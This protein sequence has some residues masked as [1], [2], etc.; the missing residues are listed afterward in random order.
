MTIEMLKKSKRYLEKLVKLRAEI[1]EIKDLQA[2][3]QLI[4]WYTV[5]YLFF[6]CSTLLVKG[7]CEF[8]DKCY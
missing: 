1:R 6:F 3:M 7:L 5:Y 4:R 2:V 8:R